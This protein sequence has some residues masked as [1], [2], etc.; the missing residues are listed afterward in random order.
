MVVAAD[1]LSGRFEGCLLG[2]AIG[3]A[4]GGKFDGR[5]T[6]TTSWRIDRRS[7]P[8]S[9]SFPETCWS[10]TIASRV[11]PVVAETLDTSRPTFGLLIRNPLSSASNAS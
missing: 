9:P 3:D 11:G 10:C 8:I 2:L 4:L 6:E 7:G 1:S 5:S